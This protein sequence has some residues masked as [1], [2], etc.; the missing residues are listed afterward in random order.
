MEIERITIEKCQD[1][2]YSIRYFKQDIKRNI[3]QEKCQW[4]FDYNTPIGK[5]RY[6]RVYNYF[7]DKCNQLEEISTDNY[8][9]RDELGNEFITELNDWHLKV[10]VGKTLNR[11]NLGLAK[12]RIQDESLSKILK[13]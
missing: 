5:N 12:P 4:W 13:N 8:I 11:I 9:L 3:W 1:D 10:A 7:L 6:E 2:I